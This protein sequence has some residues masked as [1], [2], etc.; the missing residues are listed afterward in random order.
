MNIG[1]LQQTSKKTRNLIAAALV[2]LMLIIELSDGLLIDLAECS[3][4][5][6]VL[7]LLNVVL[8]TTILI[9]SIDAWGNKE[10]FIKVHVTSFA[11]WSIVCPK[12]KL[13]DHYISINS[14]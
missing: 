4:L 1:H 9:N 8:V 5:L 14:P 6:E 12:R 2:L 11:I 3:L 7:T 13:L 10:H